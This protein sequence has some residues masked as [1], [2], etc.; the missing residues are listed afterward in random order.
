[1]STIVILS[2]RIVITVLPPIQTSGLNLENMPQLMKTTHT[3]MSHVFDTTSKEL[4]AELMKDRSM[5]L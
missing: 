4:M 3:T 1:M 2:G 5:D